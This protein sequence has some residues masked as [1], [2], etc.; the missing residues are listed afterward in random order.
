MGYTH[1]NKVV[2]VEGI[3]V[4][5]KGSETA[6]IASSGTIS[7]SN[8][9]AS[10]TVY[11]GSTINIGS[12]EGMIVT[13]LWTANETQYFRVP[14]ACT[15]TGYA[16]YTVSAGT[17]RA[18]TVTLGSA[19]AEQ[20]TTGAVGALGTQGAAV[21]ITNSAGSTLA[22]GQVVKVTLGTCATSQTH[23]GVVLTLTKA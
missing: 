15:W 2:G 23:V 11:K 22:A 6:V 5:A 14:Y 4:G 18:V 9:I 21:I 16:C 20:G 10:G 1:F 13:S 8:I 3:Y 17:G 19:G 7:G 12:A